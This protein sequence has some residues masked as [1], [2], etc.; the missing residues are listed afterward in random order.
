[1]K[2]KNQYFSYNLNDTISVDNYHLEC[3]KKNLI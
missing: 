3:S 2:K 1:M